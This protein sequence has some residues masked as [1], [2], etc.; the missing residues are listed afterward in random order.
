MGSQS[1]RQ[2]NMLIFCF[3]SLLLSP[4]LAQFAPGVPPPR[5]DEIKF[6]EPEG[7]AKPSQGTGPA[8]GTGPAPKQTPGPGE[9]RRYQPKHQDININLEREREH[10][11]A[12]VK[13]DYMDINS[14]DDTKLLMQYFRKHDTDNNHK[15]DGLELLKAITRMEEEHKHD[16]EDDHHD[17]APTDPE[18]RFS[19]EQIVPIV[20]S[21]LEQ[22]DKNKD[23]Y[24]NYAEFMARQKQNMKK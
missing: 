22:D 10:I 17:E 9:R 8:H 3:F 11:K 24:L 12:Q 14:L 13:E 18:Y 19:I 21:I 2:S 20:D 5:N 1:G 15:L 7:P 23:G 4:L 16:D 6:H